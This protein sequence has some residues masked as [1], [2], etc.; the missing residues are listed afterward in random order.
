MPETWGLLPKSQVD[1]ELIEEAIARLILEHNEDETA[2]LGTGQSLQSHKASEIIDH[3]VASIVADKLARFSVSLDKFSCNKIIM[4][5]CFESLDGWKQDV[6]SG[7]SINHFIFSVNIR[8]GAVTG[9]YAR[10]YGDA[11]DEDFIDFSKKI[12]F[13]TSVAIAFSSSQLAYIVCGSYGE[14]NFG[15]KI[16]GNSLYAYNQA[17]PNY[18][19]TLIATLS[20]GVYN[21]L[22]AEFDPVAA[23]IEF[24]VNDTLVATHTTN[25]PSSPQEVFMDFYIETETNAYRDLWLRDL[26]FSRDR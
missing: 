6:E 14:D 19:E 10:L 26:L 9:R 20:V 25:L 2:H 24:F 15:F 7:G 8:T 5:S 21:I 23:K 3:V 13:Q 11:V 17:L 1:D 12:I 16:S 22:R 4:V 18:T